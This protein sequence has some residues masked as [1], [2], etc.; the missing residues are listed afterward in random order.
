MKIFMHVYLLRSD[1]LTSINDYFLRNVLSLPS[2]QAICKTILSDLWFVVMIEGG[3][4]SLLRRVIVCRTLKA[5]ETF[6][7]ARPLNP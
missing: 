6:H 7:C 3:C 2:L 1:N 4:I 5:F